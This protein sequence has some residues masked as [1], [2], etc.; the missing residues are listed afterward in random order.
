MSTAGLTVE[1]AKGEC[2]FGQHEIGFKYAEAMRACDQHVIYKN[3]T[4]EIAAQEN[5]SITFM[6]KVNAREGN[7]CH[8]H[9]SLRD[10]DGGLV[11]AGDGENGFSPVFSRFLAG[12]LEFMPEL[13]LLL[14]PN[15]NSYKRYAAG[16][17]APT[18][19]AWGLD[20]R[21]CALRVV[22]HGA[23]LR[24]ENRAPGAD[25]NPYLACAALVVAG[26]AGVDRE[27]P[28][29][30]ALAGN[31]YNSDAPRLPTTLR[32]AR[33]LFA[34]SALAREAFGDAVVDHY[35]N[36]A[37]VELAAF[38]SAVTDWELKRGF[39]RL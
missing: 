13:T 19:I 6:A 20:N 31:G 3:G 11:F 29:P 7:S 27:L 38:E 25:V 24:F 12:Q 10:A 33:D 21:T 23:S 39:E 4:K 34:A 18:A 22:G 37:D 35:V 14:A 9:F 15:I 16:S 2:N 8:I 28:L 30:P 1:S 32:A 36:M 26:L 17:F 5:V